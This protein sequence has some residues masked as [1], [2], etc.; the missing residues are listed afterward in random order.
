MTKPWECHG[1]YYCP[2]QPVRRRW[3]AGLRKEFDVGQAESY[4]TVTP[5]HFGGLFKGAL[6]HRPELDDWAKLKG[7]TEI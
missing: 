4:Q 5:P 6:V 3:L 7:G 2:E 1:I